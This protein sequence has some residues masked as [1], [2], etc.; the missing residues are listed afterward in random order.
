MG[1]IKGSVAASVDELK[2]S[3]KASGGGS[4][5]FLLRVGEDEMKSL[6]ILAEPDQGWMPYWEHFV[7][8]YGFFPCRDGDCLGCAEDNTPSRRVAIPVYDMDEERVRVLAATKSV[9][10]DI[11]R[12]YDKHHTVRDRVWEISRVGKGL[13]DTKYTVDYR[14][15]EKSERK[16]LAAIAESEMPDIEAI[17]EAQLPNEDDDLFND[18]PPR[19]A[20]KKSSPLP[21]QRRPLDDDF[22][23]EDD[24]EPE[25]AHRPRKATAKKAVVVRKK[26]TS[27]K[28]GRLL[29]R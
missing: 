15:L 28:T 9:A 13:N 8:D 2:K 21:R 12:R 26:S 14:P 29:G 18:E 10:E 16:K 6:Y 1:K 25:W 4:V 11:L 17:L 20:S 23:D 19:R 24:D 5:E 27:K 7:Q 3:L 22:D